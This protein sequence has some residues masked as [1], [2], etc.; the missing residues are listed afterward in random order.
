MNGIHVPRRLLNISRL[1]SIIRATTKK[2][3]ATTIEKNVIAVA[4]GVVQAN[5]RKYKSDMAPKIR[6]AA[7]TW[8]TSVFCRDTT[9]MPIPIIAAHR[10]QPI[11][12]CPSS[13]MLFL[14]LI[15]HPFAGLLLVK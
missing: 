9:L 2:S 3:I 14:T 15:S 6:G 10:A 5:L 4:K 1:P 8:I 13:T 12:A 11:S 7:I